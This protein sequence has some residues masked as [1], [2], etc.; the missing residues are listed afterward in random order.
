[1]SESGELIMSVTV[2]E[3]WSEKIDR[4]LRDLT[5]RTEDLKFKLQDLEA[6]FINRR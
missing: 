5:R 3:K 1:M 2:I 6:Q 4:Y